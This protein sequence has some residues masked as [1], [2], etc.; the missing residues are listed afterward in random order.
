MGKAT[1]NIRRDR[2]VQGDLVVEHPICIARAPITV[3]DR[4]VFGRIEGA[5]LVK[6]DPKL[7]VRDPRGYRDAQGKLSAQGFMGHDGQGHGCA[8]LQDGK[9]G[10]GILVV[11]ARQVIRIGIGAM[12]RGLFG[13]GFASTQ[14][15]VL[16]H[17]VTRIAIGRG[18]IAAVGQISSRNDQRIILYLA[19]HGKI[20][21]AQPRLGAV[22]EARVGGRC[23][24][25]RRHG[26]V[27]LD[28]AVARDI[29]ELRAVILEVKRD[30]LAECLFEQTV[31]VE[32]DPGLQVTIACYGHVERA[33]RALGQDGKGDPVF[34]VGPDQVIRR[35]RGIRLCNQ[36]DIRL[37]QAQ[38]HTRRGINAVGRCQVAERCIAKVHTQPGKDRHRDQRAVTICGVQRIAELVFDG[39]DASG[40]ARGHNNAT[41]FGTGCF[42]NRHRIAGV[43]RHG[44]GQYSQRRGREGGGQA[45]DCVIR[46]D[47]ACGAAQQCVHGRSGVVV[48][49]RHNIRRGVR[50]CA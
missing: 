24:R 5:A 48:V 49:L 6:I 47:F 41:G 9:D 4:D 30:T 46:H 14:I 12:L 15:D 39:V 38:I 19:I 45:V 29:V 21:C 25:I 18:R 42:Q 13:V 31:A 28:H 11:K 40:N 1:G 8:G 22:A 2:N 10:D 23:G 44:F 20:R 35:C 32:I 7:Q 17:D 37:D 27:D 26:N 36:F 50:D 33:D 34:V 16:D 3:V 43:L